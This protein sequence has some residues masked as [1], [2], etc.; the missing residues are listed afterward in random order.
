M[1]L[2]TNFFLLFTTDIIY[3]HMRAYCNCICDFQLIGNQRGG[4]GELVKLNSFLFSWCLLVRIYSR[5]KIFTENDKGGVLFMRGKIDKQTT[6]YLSEDR[7]P[8]SRPPP[9]TCSLTNVLRVTNIV[10]SCVWVT[11]GQL[12]I[13][14]PKFK[15]H[16]ILNRQCKVFGQ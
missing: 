8:P 6:V 15:G 1:T 12:R 16:L 13:K 10:S 3:T 2:L 9:L 4:G 5:I 7:H 14:T 11:S